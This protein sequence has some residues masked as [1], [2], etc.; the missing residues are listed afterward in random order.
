MWEYCFSRS[1]IYVITTYKLNPYPMSMFVNGN[2]NSIGSDVSEPVYNGRLTK[3]F[4]L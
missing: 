2:E 1:D 3:L 4:L